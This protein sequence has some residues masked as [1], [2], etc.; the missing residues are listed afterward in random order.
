M[1]I[2]WVCLW[3]THVYTHFEAIHQGHHNGVSTHVSVCWV[4]TPIGIHDNV[5]AG[6]DCIHHRLR[7]CH[8]QICIANTIYHL[9]YTYT[10]YCICYI[11]PFYSTILQPAI[12]ITITTTITI[13]ITIIWYIAKFTTHHDG[14]KIMIY[15]IFIFFN[16]YLCIYI[17]VFVF[18]YVY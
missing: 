16:V 7:G 14:T 11:S 12:H 15:L 5:S 1:Q 10:M 6:S 4:S 13:T 9:L 3:P 18:I 17:Y 2:L 8:A